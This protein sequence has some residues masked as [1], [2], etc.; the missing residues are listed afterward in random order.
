ML[1]GGSWSIQPARMMLKGGQTSVCVQVSW[2]KFYTFHTSVLGLAF[3]RFTQLLFGVPLLS[4][5]V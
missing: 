1:T 2:R 4:H 3:V 5:V